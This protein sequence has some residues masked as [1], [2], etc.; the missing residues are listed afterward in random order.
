[1]AT[2]SSYLARLSS[3]KQSITPEEGKSTIGGIK[4]TLLDVDGEIL[5]A[6]GDDATEWHR[7]ACE[8]KTGYPGLDYDD[9]ITIFKG[10]VTGLKMTDD[11]TG[12]ELTVTDVAKWLQRDVFRGAESSSVTIQGNPMNILMAILTSTGAGTNGDYDWYDATDGLGIDDDFVNVSNIES[13]RD[14][15]LP[16]TS[17]YMRFTI[18]ERISALDFIEKEICKPL[19]MYPIIRSDGSF[20]VKLFQPP[21]N[22]TGLE[23]LDEDSIIGLPKFDANFDALIN[24]VEWHYNYSAGSYANQRFYSSAS[25]LAARGPGKKPLV[26]KTQGLQSADVGTE[27]FS[28]R[29]HRVFDRYLTPPPKI[30]CETF[31]SKWVVE[32][33]DIVKF[34][35]SQVPDIE[36]GTRG[37]TD[38]LMEV[39]SREVDLEKG[40][41][42]FELLWT[43]F[44]LGNYLRISPSGTVVTGSSATSFTMSSADA[45]KFKVGWEISITTA[46]GDSRGD[47]NITAING[48]AITIEDLGETPQT[49]DKVVFANAGSLVSAQTSADYGSIGD[50]AVIFG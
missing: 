15:W 30:T 45:A 1:M 47:V 21:W 22:D 11:G 2:T 35:H 50:G 19:N 5:D 27:V 31:F 10:W 48:T 40:K 12:F 28:R 38:E 20:D 23:T 36:A 4:L 46:G 33:G 39:I 18:T 24:E 6:I 14:N 3:L 25:S 8:I 26:I 7:E 44:G 42:K 49:G 16:G 34:T 17:H 13:I 32:P 29:R 41:V 43:G 37:L 9:Y